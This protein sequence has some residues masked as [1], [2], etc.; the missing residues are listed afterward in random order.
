MDYS[1]LG[2]SDIQVSSVGLGTWAM[3]NDFW[4]EVDD[5][6]SIA[7][8][9]ASIEAGINLID[10]APVY[11]SGHSEEVV[12][13]AIA[14]RREQV[15]ISTKCGN[16]RTADGFVR[17]FSPAFLRQGIEDSLRRLGTDMIDI[18]F[19]HWPDP[20][21]PLEPGIEELVRLHKAGKFRH[22]ALS[23]F[24]IDLIEQV[25]AAVEVICLQP[26]YSLLKRDIENDILPYAE[27]EG[28]GVMSYG[29]L[30]GGIL[31]GKLREIPEF[32][33]GD[34]RSRFYSYYEQPI[35]DK[36]QSLV[37]V[38]REIAADHDTSPAS[39]AI[40]WTLSQPGV[41]SVLVGAKRADQARQNAASREWALSNDEGERIEKAYDEYLRRDLE[42]R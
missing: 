17:D 3:G 7:A 10:T 21:R 30:A 14:G 35:W 28:L 33:A 29:T 18:Y 39:V 25:R 31:T 23:N 27:K 5:V 22:L 8:I 41:T 24:G 20:N 4:G 42:D 36:I 34:N 40:N 19:V 26:H 37:D 13:R 6:E 16:K 12:G 11:G 32:P 15:V 2:D 38:L 1:K 9:Q